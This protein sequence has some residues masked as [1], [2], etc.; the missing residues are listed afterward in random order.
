[1]TIEQFVNK[2]LVFASHH[3]GFK[4][5]EPSNGR[6][7]SITALNWDELKDFEIINW[8]IED[9]TPKYYICFLI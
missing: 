5:V 2:Q 9:C 4:I 7:T 6:L 8:F 1:M 3:C